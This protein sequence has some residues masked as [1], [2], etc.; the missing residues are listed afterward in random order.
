MTDGDLALRPAGSLRNPWLREALADEGDPPP[1]LPLTGRT[2]ADVVVV[3]GGYTGLWT[4]YH[5]LK[6]DP[7]LRVVLLEMVEG[8]S[9]SAIVPTAPKRSKKPSSSTGPSIPYSATPGPGR[10]WRTA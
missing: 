2:D 1:N 9:T 6:G 10:D 7:R 4:A 3:G 8:K 5:V